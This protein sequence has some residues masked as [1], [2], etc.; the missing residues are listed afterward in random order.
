MAV[1]GQLLAE[2]DQ[3]PGAR[4]GTGREKFLLFLPNHL[5]KQVPVYCLLPFPCSV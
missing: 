2:Q 4:E 1:Q 3:P 5:E